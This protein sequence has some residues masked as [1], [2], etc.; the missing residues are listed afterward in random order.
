MEIDQ[1]QESNGDEEI[2]ARKNN[3]NEFD[4]REESNPTV[5]YA[6]NLSETEIRTRKQ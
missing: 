4:V 2:F 6:V 5:T 1:Q 3:G